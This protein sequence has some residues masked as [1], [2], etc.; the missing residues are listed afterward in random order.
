M[1]KFVGALIAVLVG[2]GLAGG[3][4]LAATSANSP[5]STLDLQKPASANSAVD[6][7]TR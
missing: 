4:T 7:G 3:I 1:G 2:L 5:D 6:Y